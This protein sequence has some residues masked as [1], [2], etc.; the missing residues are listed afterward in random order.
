MRGRRTIIAVG[1]VAATALSFGVGAWWGDRVARRSDQWG[2]ERLISTA[3]DSVRANALDALPSDELLRRAVSGMLRELKDPY[4]ALLRPEG[5]REFRGLLNGD[6]PGL[7]LVMHRSG[8]QLNIARVYTG[9]PAATAGIRAGDRILSV[10][11]LLISNR[12]ALRSGNTDDAEPAF[13]KSDSN[14]IVL[15]RPLLNDTVRVTVPP[16]SWHMPAAFD[17]V[18]LSKTTGYVALT[19]ISAKS[20]EELDETIEG[21][22]D[23]GAKSLILDLRGNGG[24]LLEEGV[25]VAALFLPRNSLIAS[26]TG[27]VGTP[28]LERRATRGGKWESLPVTVLVDAHTA[29]AAEIVAG[30]LRDHKRALL[31]GEPT[32]GKGLV[33]RVVALT[34]ELSMRMTTARWMTPSGQVLERRQGSGI[35]AIGGLTPDIFVPDA[36]RREPMAPPP[37][38]SDLAAAR[39]LRVADTAAAR[40]LTEGW[41]ANT[42]TELEARLHEV[43]DAYLAPTPGNPTGRAV[44]V[45]EATRLATVRVLEVTGK[46]N[47]VLRYTVNA[48][49]ALR[50]ALDVFTPGEQDR[51]V[52][53]SQTATVSSETVSP[54][55]SALDLWIVQ[56]YKM[57]RLLPDSGARTTVTASPIGAPRVESARTVGRRDTVV[58]LQFAT[59]YGRAAL[60]TTA[61]IQLADPS[62]AVSSVTGRITAR[63]AFRT[64]RVAGARD[65]V[66]DEWRVGW[67]YLV[68]LPSRVA[69]AS[70]SGFN[71]WAV[72]EP[73]P[74]TASKPVRA[75]SPK[76]LSV[77]ATDGPSKTSATLPPAR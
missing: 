22:V 66:K 34:P 64:P 19:R 37:G 45:G 71:G 58:A 68:A 1:V 38:L 25:R 54:T 10:N 50:A 6:G 23:E 20:S 4:A 29:S 5:A 51:P 70:P 46:S 69:N 24:G 55:L 59:T 28:P 39:M 7:G 53:P 26:V 44:L 62:G 57:A 11:G 60:G 36:A 73:K 31:V 18:M 56:R 27:K 76:V 2:P 32:Y 33:Q 40:A 15:F 30:A 72:E 67:A 52:A 74:R 8:K 43:I 17:A 75:E 16:G 63:R 49:H 47:D 42:P 13:S 61:T 12:D 3:I 35:D 9:S 77:P 41:A 48:D 65:S 14:R 21:L